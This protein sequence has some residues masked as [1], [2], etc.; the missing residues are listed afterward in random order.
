MSYSL[1]QNGFD[2]LKEMEGIVLHPYR[3]KAGVPTIG[4]GTTFYE[5]GS[6]VTMD[7]DPITLDRAFQLVQYYFDKIISPTLEDRVT[8]DLNQN[9]VDALCSFIYNE[10][11]GGF[12]GSHLLQAI[13]N[14]SG[15]DAIRAE[16]GKWI[17]VNHQVDDWQVKRRKKEADLYFS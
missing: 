16:F 5:D 9:Q 2:F 12:V 8:V 13:N 14:D 4:I 7:D 6:P 3:D 11:K 17:Y 1:S 10:G 15:E